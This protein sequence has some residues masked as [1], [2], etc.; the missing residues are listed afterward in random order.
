MNDAAFARR[1]GVYA[2]GDWEF[3]LLKA[4]WDACAV[5]MTKTQG[6]ETCKA[7]PQHPMWA[8]WYEG[9]FICAEIAKDIEATSSEKLLTEIGIVKTAEHLQRVINELAKLLAPGEEGL[10]VD[11]LMDRLSLFAKEK[12]WPEEPQS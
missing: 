1:F 11:D 2:D 9:C 3:E 7:N 5:E 10:T 4:G 12:S 8:L 6:P